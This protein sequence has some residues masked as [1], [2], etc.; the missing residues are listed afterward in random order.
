MSFWRILYFSAAPQKWMVVAN[1]HNKEIKKQRR[2]E[3]KKNKITSFFIIHWRLFIDPYFAKYEN[4]LLNTKY[5]KWHHAKFLLSGD[6]EVGWLVGILL[7]ILAA[8]LCEKLHV[9]HSCINNFLHWKTAKTLFD[10]WLCV[11]MILVT[12]SV[13]EYWFKNLLISFLKSPT[14]ED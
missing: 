3:E 7:P 1:R 2:G 5:G 11:F 13:C 6:Q 9:V 12:I 4:F 8:A 14:N 10:L